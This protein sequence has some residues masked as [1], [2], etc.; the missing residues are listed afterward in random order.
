MLMKKI[1]L[2]Y[3]INFSDLDQLYTSPYLDTLK[4]LSKRFGKINIVD[5]QC[6]TFSKKYNAIKKKRTKSILNFTVLRIY[7]H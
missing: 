7:F 6:L 2:F 1:Q 3:F 4:N 5:M